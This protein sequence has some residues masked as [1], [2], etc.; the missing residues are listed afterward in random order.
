MMKIGFSS[1]ACP[2]WDLATILGKVA[3]FGYDGIELRGLVGEMDLT[4]VPDLAADP[5]GARRRFEEAKVELVCIGA[6]ASFESPDRK[7]VAGRRLKVIEFIELAGKLGCPFV[8]VF[9][10]EVP[11]RQSREG[12]L[13]RI[14]ETLQ[15]LAPIAAR[16]RVTV[17]VENTSGDYAGSRDVWY[18]VDHAAHPAIK[19]C[20]N[21]FWA[22]TVGERPTTSIPRLGTKIAMVHVCDGRFSRDGLLEDYAIPGAGDVELVRMIELL[23]GI[24]YRGY[25]MFEWPK[26]WIDRLAAA[27]QVLPQVAKFLKERIAAR[28]P[29]LT[30]YKGD[31]QAA[32]FAPLPAPLARPV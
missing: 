2:A 17:L 21:P 11:R 32:K 25:L 30:A 12:T 3:E 20:W 15:T 19:C 6:S 7:V 5:A 9:I 23:K 29:V 8:R 24:V 22:M 1:L 28:D 16:H 27:E 14:A 31:K 13:A 10:G 4:L 18:V 26:L